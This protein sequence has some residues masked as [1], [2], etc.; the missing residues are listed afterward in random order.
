M[1]VS[2]LNASVRFSLSAAVSLLAANRP[3]AEGRIQDLLDQLG[4]SESDT[5]ALGTGALQANKIWYDQRSLTTGA[6]ELLN[7]G[8]GSAPA[9]IS[10]LNI[11]DSAG[12]VT[13]SR[14]VAAFFK[15]NS[16]NPGDTLSV[17]G[18]ASYGMTTLFPAT[19]DLVIVR[20]GGKIMF[21]D[22]SPAGIV[23]AAQN[24]LKI[25]NN[26]TNTINYTAVLIGS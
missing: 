7:V 2:T 10:L 19:T 9:A 24:V 8:G 13:M 25:L 12:T 14:L 6:S 11:T 3:A 26:G 21:D 22:P 4:I 5:F 16:T 1:S 23:V 15:N 17:G 18:V 20:P